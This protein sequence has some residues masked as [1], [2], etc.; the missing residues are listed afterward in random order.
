MVLKPLNKILKCPY[1]TMISGIKTD[2][3]E[4]NEGDLFIATK[5]FFVDH[6]NYI[7]EAIKN[8]AK[9]VVTDR[10][11]EATIPILKRKDLRRALVNAC[12]NFFDYQNNINLIGVTGTDGKTTTAFILSELLNE[13]DN[14]AYM[15]TNGIKY[16]NQVT[17]IN[18][19]TPP[20]EKLYDYLSG[21]EKNGCKNCVLEVSSE[22]LL[23][24]RVSSFRFR[25]VI[26][27]NITEDHLNIHK[28]IDSYIKAKMSLTKLLE[29]DGIIISNGDDIVQERL[30]E[31]K[32]NQVITYGKSSQC[33]FRILNIVEKENKTYFD[34]KKENEIYHIESPYLGEY[35]VYNLTACFIVCYLEKMNIVRVIEKIKGLGSVPGRGEVL[36][37]SNDYK[38][39]LDYAHTYHSIESL[40]KCFKKKAK[41]LIVVTGAA[42][43]R[44]K[45]KRARIGKLLL[46]QCNLVIFTMDDP[47]FE[48]V[49]SIIDDMLK[50]SNKTN[51]LRIIDR[52]KAIKRALSIAKKNDYVLIIGKG[53]DSYMAIEDRYEDYSDYEVIQSYFLK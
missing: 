1:Q 35:N 14:T 17:K 15:G 51:Y 33:D 5:G 19:T 3:R 22:S 48:R 37:F 39:V 2:S 30:R 26:Y 29:K 25:Y 13:K 8:G 50:E 27:T 53:R 16:K 6:S 41:N 34:I 21:L 36:S 47:R 46:E 49:D 20:T 11:Y 42:G 40:I 9:A 43:G 7:G 45:E 31:I 4:V 32:K 10:D 44:E 38:I 23:H 28:N 24:K 52:K 12:I 18:N